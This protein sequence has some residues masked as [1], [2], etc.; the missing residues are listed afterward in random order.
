MGNLSNENISLELFKYRKEHKLTLAQMVARLACDECKS[1]G[2]LSEVERGVKK[3]N[4]SMVFAFEKLLGVVAD[5]VPAFTPQPDQIAEQHHG[6]SPEVK[7]AA[8]Y[9]E[10]KVKGKTPA[11]RLKAVEEIMEQ[12]RELF[13]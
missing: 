8:D 13:K 10:V 9:L 11:E 1:P 5:P 6:Y 2:F 3:A 12:I 7:L 4:A